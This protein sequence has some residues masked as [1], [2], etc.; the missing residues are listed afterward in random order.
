M[1]KTIFHLSL[2]TLAAI[3]F[4]LPVLSADA[5]QLQPN[6]VELVQPISAEYVRILPQ[7]EPVVDLSA[8]VI[9]GEPVVTGDYFPAPT[10]AYRERGRCRKMCCDCEPPIETA[11]SV[12]QPRCCDSFVEVPIC[13]PGCCKSAPSVECRKGLFCNGVVT[14]R[15]NCGFKVIVVFKKSGDII[16]T[17]IRC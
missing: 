8:H 2:V 10:I 6:G 3:L 11:L 12:E 9:V 14:Y 17:S 7:P 5:D 1:K 4:V 16:V 15:W 13:L